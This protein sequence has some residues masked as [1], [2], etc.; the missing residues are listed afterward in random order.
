VWD[1]ASG[2]SLGVL[3][4]HLFPVYSA[5]FSPDGSRIVT[6]SVDETARVWRTFPNTKSLIDYAKS[7][8]PRELTAEQ[9]QAFFL[10]TGG[11]GPKVQLTWQPPFIRISNL[12]Q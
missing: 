4:G 10:D 6:A 11:E 7:Q 5:A 3:Q 8:L 9:R 2:R 12:T 1:A